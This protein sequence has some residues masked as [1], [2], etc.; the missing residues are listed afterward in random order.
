MAGCASATVGSGPGT[1]A[2]TITLWTHNA[3]DFAEPGVVK[4]TSVMAA[5]SA[6]K[7]PC[8]LDS[9]GPN[10]PNWAW[11]NCLAPLDLSGGKVKVADQL[12]STVGRYKVKVHPFGFHDVDLTMFTR[13]WVL[14]TYGIRV[15][16]LD[17]PR[18]KDD[19]DAAP[20]RINAGGT[21][22]NALDM[23]T[24]DSGEWWPYAYSPQ[25]HSYDGDL[26]DRSTSRIA[27][28]RAA[29]TA[30]PARRPTPG[31]RSNRTWRPTGPS[32]N[33]PSAPEKP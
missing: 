26:I 13:T 2:D 9:D 10:V 33:S 29:L 16:A 12:P 25:L 27:E 15:P 30:S 18:T 4:R 17:K 6:N 23:Q 14:T 3:S 19:F 7:L 20:A 1:G 24:G 21:F 11:D 31:L 32:S 28:R 5:A 22:K 8:V